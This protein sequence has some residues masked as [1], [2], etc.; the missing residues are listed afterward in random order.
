MPHANPNLKADAADEAAA[1]QE[2]LKLL[3]MRLSLNPTPNP[4]PN[5][6]RRLLEE[7]ASRRQAEE[8]QEVSH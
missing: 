8:H 2:Q 7:E 4:E 3:E 1:L 6:D 5:P